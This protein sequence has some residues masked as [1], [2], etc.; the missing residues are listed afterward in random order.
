MA[1]WAA[2]GLVLVLGLIGITLWIRRGATG[3][4]LPLSAEEKQRLS[5]LTDK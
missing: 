1:L 5:K 2:P 3:N 4:P